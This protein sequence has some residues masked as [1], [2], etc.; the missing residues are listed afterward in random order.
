MPL[1]FGVTLGLVVSLF[2]VSFSWSSSVISTV[3]HGRVFSRFNLYAGYFSI[4]QLQLNRSVNLLRVVEA[5]AIRRETVSVRNFVDSYPV[6]GCVNGS[7]FSKNNVPLGVVISRGK[8]LNPVHHSHG[9]LTNIVGVSADGRVKFVSKNDGMPTDLLEAMQTSA[10]FDSF[11]SFARFGAGI[12]TRKSGICALRGGG[13]RLISFTAFPWVGSGLFSSFDE[14]CEKIAQ[15][16]GGSS[17]ALWFKP[18]GDSKQLF[19]VN[20]N[21]YVP[22]M[23]CVL[24]ETDLSDKLIFKKWL[25]S[26]N[27]YLGSLMR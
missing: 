25:H 12:L 14:E 17:S 2:W 4:A 16:D 3:V 15:L 20:E 23:F 19:G 22:V 18:R 6:Y 13:I 11:A 10:V 7:F 27:T 21:A 8:L 24:Q 26:K 1:L 9:T 5:S